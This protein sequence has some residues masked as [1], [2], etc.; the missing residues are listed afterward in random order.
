VGEGILPAFEVSVE[1]CGF[2]F[3]LA[4]DFLGDDELLALLVLDDAAPAEKLVL[5][6]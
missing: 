4:D 1:L 5:V 3:V 2:S 6:D